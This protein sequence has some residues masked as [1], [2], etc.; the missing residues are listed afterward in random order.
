MKT[1]PYS[2]HS[3]ASAA[4]RQ[5]ADSQFMCILSSLQLE[6]ECR[7]ACVRERQ[8]GRQ[9]LLSAVVAVV[10]MQCCHCCL[11]SPCSLTFSTSLTPVV[12]PP[13]LNPVS[14]LFLLPC[15]FV[16]HFFLCC[17]AFHTSVFH[18]F[19]FCLLLHFGCLSNVYCIHLCIM[20][21]RNVPVPLHLGLCR[22]Q[23]RALPLHILANKQQAGFRLLRYCSRPPT[24][25][26][27]HTLP[28]RLPSCTKRILAE[29]RTWQHMHTRAKRHSGGDVHAHL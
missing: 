15:S 28:S 4:H 24:C 26:H 2:P 22:P 16:L 7:N 1:S 13:L 14:L 5:L 18:L 17:C 23:S 12:P 29:E 3:D 20:F 25:K 19:I 10:M 21:M 11:S 6:E 8:L 27:T 9:P